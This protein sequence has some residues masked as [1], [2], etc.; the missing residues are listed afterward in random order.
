MIDDIATAAGLFIKYCVIFFFIAF[1]IAILSSF[2]KKLRN[3]PITLAK[4]II[5]TL[6]PF[7]AGIGIP[8][9]LL[10]EQFQWPLLL[11]IIIGFYIYTV[12]QNFIEKRMDV[13][14]KDE[15]D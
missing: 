7:V 4:I 10:H 8:Y 9:F 5:S 3:E 1:G 15:N 13:R 2:L 6:A 11:N 12:V 14:F